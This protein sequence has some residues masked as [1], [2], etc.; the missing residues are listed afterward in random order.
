MRLPVYV[1]NAVKAQAKKAGIPYT[2]Y[3]TAVLEKSIAKPQRRVA[4]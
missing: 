2:A 1:I 4:S 3:I